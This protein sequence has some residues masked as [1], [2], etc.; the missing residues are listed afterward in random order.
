MKIRWTMP[1]DTDYYG[2]DATP[3]MVEALI[4]GYEAA[5]RAF[6]AERWPEAVLEFETV[7]E[8]T[9]FGNR[10]GVSAENSQQEQEIYDAINSFVE[11]YWP[12][13]LPENWDAENEN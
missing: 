7:P 11:R 3:Q 8:T 13:W 2:Y 4:P 6:V 12:E 5:V 9:S 1:T 10:G